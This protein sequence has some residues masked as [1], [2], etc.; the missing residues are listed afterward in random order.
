[1]NNFPE[2]CIRGIAKGSHINTD[3][4]T[5]VFR[6]YLPDTRTSRN[7][8]D[9]GSETS[10]NWEDDDTTL[11]FTLEYRENSDLAFPYGAVRL[12]RAEIDHINELPSTENTIF[13]ERSPNDKNKY[14]GNIVFKNGLP[15]PKKNMVASC[16]A[17]ASSKVISRGSL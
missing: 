13:Y 4:N 3:D 5:I 14:H 12:A 7:R 16:L 6:D 8:I 9:G 15:D 2:F 1:M 10:I 17:A 11:I